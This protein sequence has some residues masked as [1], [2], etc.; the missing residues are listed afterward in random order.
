M[1]NNERY[2]EKGFTVLELLV[3]LTI[4][5]LVIGLGVPTFKAYSKKIEI[6]NGLRTVTLA[7]NTA[8]YKA[9]ENNRSIKLKVE[10][11][12]LIL[13]EKRDSAWESFMDFDPGDRV[14]V[15]L[16]TSPVFYPEG[17]IVPLCSFYV[18]SNEENYKISISIAGRIKVTEL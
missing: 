10:E 13:L 1:N 14:S 18:R 3:T 11:N 17:Y 16:N 4:F 8:R 2:G 15:S 9:I 5:A 7:V 12:R 6:N